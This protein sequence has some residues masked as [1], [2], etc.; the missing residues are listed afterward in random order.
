MVGGELLF[1]FYNGVPFNYCVLIESPILK[2][3]AHR[4]VQNFLSQ[5][6][7]TTF[8]DNIPTVER[9]LNE[10]YMKKIDEETKNDDV[11]NEKKNTEDDD[12]EAKDPKVIFTLIYIKT[13]C[14]IFHKICRILGKKKKRTGFFFF[15]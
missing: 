9:Y 3:Y 14:K 15:G 1:L 13:G 6:F 11:K 2:D 5:E 4:L 7:T 10:K 8:G 12:E